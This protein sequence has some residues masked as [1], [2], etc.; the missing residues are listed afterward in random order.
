MKAPL[1]NVLLTAAVLI[2]VSA[3]AVEVSGK[4][5]EVYGKIHVSIDNSDRDDPAVTNDGMSISSNSSR[6]GFKGKKETE[7]GIDIIW[8][9]EQEVSFDDASAGN[10]ANRNTYVG[11]A[12]NNQL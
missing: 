4:T 5:L 7:S 6:L 12:G 11:L 8:Q 1:K 9:V 10:F 3:N 2:P